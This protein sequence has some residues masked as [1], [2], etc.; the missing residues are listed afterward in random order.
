MSQTL[1]A[2]ESTQTTNKFACATHLCSAAHR[3][4]QKPV[5]RIN[6]ERTPLALLATH[7]LPLL[8]SFPLGPSNSYARNKKPSH[9]NDDVIL[10][11][12]PRISSLPRTS[13]A[14]LADNEC[15][16]H[17]HSFVT[18]Q[19]IS[20]MMVLRRILLRFPAEA[21]TAVYPETLNSSVLVLRCLL[22]LFLF[23]AYLLYLSLT[24]LLFLDKGGR[25]TSITRLRRSCVPRLMLLHDFPKLR[26]C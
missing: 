21:L 9:L 17:H 6:S 22:S 16:R 1:A 25:V 8:P 12:S 24:F 2:V 26:S 11:F 20:I 18:F 14:N 10:L 13:K 4:L 3:H 23:F 7:L 15:Q 5:I 19:K